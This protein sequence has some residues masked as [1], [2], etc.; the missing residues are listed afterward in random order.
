MVL[1]WPDVE[2]VGITTTADP[3]GRRAG[4]VK[5][6]LQ[7]AGRDGIS[8]AV[9]AGRSLT[10]GQAMGD[11]PDHERYWGMPVTAVPTAEGAATA[12][13]VRSLEQ[14]ATIAAIGPYTNLAV[15]ERAS[16]GVL[17]GAPVTVM[18]G[19]VWPP[20]DGLPAWGPAVDWNVQCDTRAAEAVA[21]TADLTMCLLPTTMT[22]NLRAADLSRLAASGPIGAL[23]A[24]QSAAYAEDRGR[25]EVG[26]SYPGL[27]DDLVNFHWDPVACALALG[28]PGATTEEVRLR[29][30]VEDGVLRF[31]PQEAGRPIRVLTRVDGV[32]F[33]ERWI[34]AV[35]AAQRAR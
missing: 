19:W 34:T 15:L 17:S 5:R 25:T 11:I 6:F 22:A 14:G 33:S 12:L 2:V 26:R 20:A 13:L 7:L 29:P 30:V 27:P 10:T 35:E 18:G 8:V 16:P 21:A 9:G 4:Y 23:L 28:W 1:G 32:G 24:R 3:D 31:A